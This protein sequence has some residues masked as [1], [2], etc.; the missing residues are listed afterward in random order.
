MIEMSLCGKI[1]LLIIMTQMIL[2][3]KSCLY[4]TDDSKTY[5]TH[6]LVCELILLKPYDT[7]DLVSDV[8]P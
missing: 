2:S 7:D 8:L 5:D 3:E 6:G 4:D 1:C